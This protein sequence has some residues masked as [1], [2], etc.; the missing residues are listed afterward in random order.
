VS[1]PVT[2]VWVGGGGADR[3]VAPDDAG[4][5]EDEH[6][7]LVRDARRERGDRLVL[8]DRRDGPGASG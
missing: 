3:G 2:G 8:A 5:V 4:A 6:V 7:V 1:V